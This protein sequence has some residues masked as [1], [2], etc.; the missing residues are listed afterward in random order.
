MH[1]HIMV[2]RITVDEG[3]SYC[4]DLYIIHRLLLFIQTIDINYIECRND[5]QYENVPQ[6]VANNQP[7]CNKVCELLKCGTVADLW[8]SDVNIL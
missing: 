1:S 2:S 8:V 5:N 6:T 4:R 3:S 7:N